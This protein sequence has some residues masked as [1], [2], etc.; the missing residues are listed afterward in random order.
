MFDVNK[1]GV[2]T[3]AD[4]RMV[5]APLEDAVPVWTQLHRQHHAL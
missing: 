1:T 4:L 2:L 5:F 3:A